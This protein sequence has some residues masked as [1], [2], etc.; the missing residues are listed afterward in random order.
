MLWPNCSTVKDALTELKEILSRSQAN[1]SPNQRLETAKILAGIEAT[2]SS[3]EEK[4]LAQGDFHEDLGVPTVAGLT[5]P[6]AAGN[7]GN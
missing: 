5:A 3:I 4:S 2:I 6:V 7:S 1:A